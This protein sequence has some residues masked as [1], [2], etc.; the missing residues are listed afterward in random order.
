M[1][2]TASNYHQSQPD[3]VSRLALFW[4][5]C[6]EIKQMQTQWEAQLGLHRSAEWT[7]LRFSGYDI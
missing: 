7:G 2:Q 1:V 6:M 3:P 5:P 4:G